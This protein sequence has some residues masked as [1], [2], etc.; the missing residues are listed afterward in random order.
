MYLIRTK[1]FLFYM[2]V[3]DI[4][5]IQ[6][7]SNVTSMAYNEKPILIT[8]FLCTTKV[9]TLSI[10]TFFSFKKNTFHNFS[11]NKCSSLLLGFM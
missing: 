4:V 11:Y 2:E 10:V 7:K 8:I 1:N 3:Y 6:Q 9:I 5:H